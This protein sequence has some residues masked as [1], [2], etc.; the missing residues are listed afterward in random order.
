LVREV[1]DAE[2]FAVVPDLFPRSNEVAQ[3]MSSDEND[4]PRLMAEL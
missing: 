2:S 3:L 1:G 4:V